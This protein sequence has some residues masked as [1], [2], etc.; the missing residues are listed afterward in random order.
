MS[1]WSKREAFIV[2]EIEKGTPLAAI[3]AMADVKYP[4]TVEPEPPSIMRTRKAEFVF[5]IH[6]HDGYD[7]TTTKYADVLE[8]ETNLREA[9]KNCN[10]GGYEMEKVIMV[11]IKESGSIE[12]LEF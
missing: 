7:C 11:A 8:M 9:S 2:E 1:N 6:I 5:C 4:K 12:A 3:K 10:S